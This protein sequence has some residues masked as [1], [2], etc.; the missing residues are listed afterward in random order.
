MNKEMNIALKSLEPNKI[1]MRKYP[2]YEDLYQIAISD[3]FL[4][5]KEELI[6]IYNRKELGKLFRTIVLNNV[7]WKRSKYSLMFQSHVIYSDQLQE[8]TRTVTPSI[9]L[10][11]ECNKISS[12]WYDSYLLKEYAELGSIDKVSELTGIPRSSISNTLIKLK[13]RMQ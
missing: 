13:K 12:Y 8:Q 9:D 1:W 3:L 4:K 10:E 7:R 2:Q 11:K 5:Y 6:E